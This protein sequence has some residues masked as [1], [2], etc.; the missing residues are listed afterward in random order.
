PRQWEDAARLLDKAHD[1][2]A[3]L[4]M[5]PPH[6]HYPVARAALAAGKHC[7]VEKPGSLTAAQAADLLRRSREAGRRIAVD[8]VMR[9][10]P[11]CRFVRRCVETGA[12]GPLERVAIENCAHDDTLPPDHWFWDETRSGGIWVEHGVHFFDAV[13]WW[14]G[15]PAR[16]Q[17]LALARPG[18]EGEEAGATT[19]RQ[20]TV[21]ANAVHVAPGGEAVTATYYHGFTRPEAFERT[22]WHLVFQRAYVDLYGWMPVDLRLEALVPDEPPPVLQEL[23]GAT[24]CTLET[25]PE[26]TSFRGRGRDYAARRRV[27]VTAHLGDR[28]QVYALCVQAGLADFL[29]AAADPSHCP[30]VSF[31]DAVA[32]LA[33]AEAARSAQAGGATVTV[34]RLRTP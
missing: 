13:T 25:Y 4:I 33:A 23:P 28:W 31:A 17:A 15:P 24:V 12:F 27:E 9:H 11:L 30:A 3:V 32:A 19:P 29:R 21:V 22:G 6:L 18:G 14:A 1:V 26:G 16:L 8:F 7:F 5:T 20:D 2:A 34:G 10:N